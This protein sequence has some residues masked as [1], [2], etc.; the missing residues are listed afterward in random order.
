MRDR[1]PIKEKNGTA[2]HIL[3][4]GAGGMIGR[5]LAAELARTGSLGG[6]KIDGMTLADVTRPPI[7][8]GDISAV[9]SI[10]ADISAPGAATDLAARR[11][12]VIFHL[13]AIVSGEAERDFEKGY[14]INLD[15][16][17]LLFEAIRLEGAGQKYVPRLVF[18]SSV[19]VYGAP[20]SDPIPD[21]YILAPLTSYGTQKAISELLLADYSRRGFLDGVGIR[22]PTIVIR[23]GAPNAA[24]SG[25][26]SGILREPLAGQRSVLPVKETVKHWLASPRSAVAFLIHAATLDTSPLGARRTLNMPGVAATV[27]DQL[28]ALRRVAGAEAEALIDRRPDTAIEAIIAGWPKS[29]SPEQAS[30]LGFVAE[31]TV[32]ELIEVYLTDDAP[33]LAPDRQP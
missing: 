32:D 18:T 2:M 21:D 6:R 20:L 11:A 23:P 31:S 30:S 33:K 7:P 24:A 28:A 26:F 15:G 14:R 25:F 29:F 19:A 3:I 10:A 13:A 27:S 22:L 4:I 12:D 8:T 1:E 16:T 5:K 17:R 9:E